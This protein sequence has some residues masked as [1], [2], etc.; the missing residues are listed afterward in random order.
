MFNIFK[1]NKE[2]TEVEQEKELASVKFYITNVQDPPRVSINIDSYDNEC[3]NSLC[4][5]VSL[6]SEEYLT[7]ETINIIKQY[8]IENDKSDIFSSIALKLGEMEAFK[9]EF[10]STPESS[11]ITEPC[12]KPSD[13]S[14]Y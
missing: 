9:K 6:L 14:N 13:L 5:I 2:E 7:V 11:H 3:I 4:C 12:I 8:M 1:R 10:K